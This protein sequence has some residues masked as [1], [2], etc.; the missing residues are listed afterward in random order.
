MPPFSYV[1]ILQSNLGPEHFYIGLTQDLRAR[2]KRHNA[3]EVSALV[4]LRLQVM[5]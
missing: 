1:Y 5:R 4:N 2:L 3:G